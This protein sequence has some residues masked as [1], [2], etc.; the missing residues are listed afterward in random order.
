V[1]F[2]SKKERI[3]SLEYSDGNC[4]KEQLTLNHFLEKIVAPSDV[5]QV[6][7]CPGLE[8]LQTD[9]NAFVDSVHMTC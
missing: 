3:E 2:F 7:I 9:Q 8:S 6:S 4:R 1:E 5:M